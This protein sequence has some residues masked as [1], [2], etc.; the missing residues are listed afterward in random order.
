MVKHM[1]LNHASVVDTLLDL[2]ALPG[3]SGQEE[4][5]L[6]WCRETW[7]S[8]G[9]DVSTSPI[10]NVYA[11]LAG[12][13]PRLLLQGHADEISFVVR[14]IDERGFLWLADGQG[15][16]RQ[17]HSRYPV[18][19]PA[20]ILTRTGPV[21]GVFASPTGHILSTLAGGADSIRD[22]AN[23]VFVDIGVDTRYEAEALGVHPGAG[24]I[25]NPESRRMGHRIVG[26]AI[27]NRVS[28]ALMT[29]LIA[30][31]A[32]GDLTCDL[33]IA[34]TVQEEIGLVGALS[35]GTPDRFDLALA[36]D[37]G[38]IADYP[39]TDL[40]ELPVRLGGGPTIVYKDSM[41]HYDRRVIDRLHEVAEANLIT[42]QPGVY[43]GFGS[44]GAALMRSGVPTALVAVS[45]RYTHSPF[46]MADARDVEASL[47]LLRA[48]VT[49]PFGPLPLGPS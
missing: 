36:I 17:F 25:W 13:G 38:P 34:A 44:D 48:F 14:G 45:T 11:H 21:S 29:H 6:A 49:T 31:V 39:G 23:T 2:M 47:D 28:L 35:L 19:Q 4:P 5:V 10:G 16:S 33:T 32:A 24:V 15:S 37:N 22:T 7:T 3:P 12:P 30:A 26:K 46:E 27:D 18:G 41:V 8:L 20:L 1:P 42:I 40:G 9:A 43:S